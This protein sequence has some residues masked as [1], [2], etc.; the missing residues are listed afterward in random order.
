MCCVRLSMGFVYLVQKKS[1]IYIYY[2]I[3]KK[4]SVFRCVI[5]KSYKLVSG[6]VLIE[7]MP[8]DQKKIVLNKLPVVLSNNF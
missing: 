1:K 3:V 2:D 5:K 4:M 6:P 7:T 8:F